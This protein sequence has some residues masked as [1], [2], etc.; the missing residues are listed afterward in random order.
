[1]DGY[2]GRLCERVCFFL[3]H[4][5][6]EA[7]RPEAAVLLEHSL[8]GVLSELLNEKLLA[9]FL[10]GVREKMCAD[11]V[12]VFDSDVRVTSANFWSM[13]IEGRSGLDD[14]S[15]ISNVFTA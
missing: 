3:G 5:P 12:L 13:S 11:R 10:N 14:Y 15:E 6:K 9:L 1:M 2:G 7:R 4:L 8:G